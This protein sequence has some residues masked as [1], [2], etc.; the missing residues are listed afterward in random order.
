MTNLGLL[1]DHL[2]LGEDYSEQL[3][4]VLQSALDEITASRARLLELGGYSPAVTADLLTG[5]GKTTQYT[6]KFERSDLHS[7]GSSALICVLVAHENQRTVLDQLVTLTCQDGVW[8]AQIALDEFPGHNS[9]AA[10]MDKLSDWLI[11]RGLATRVSDSLRTQLEA[12]WTK[13]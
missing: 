3:L 13:N 10:A 5:C 6:T 8:T 9:P 12:L 7:A 2:A 1:K 11:R 4:Q